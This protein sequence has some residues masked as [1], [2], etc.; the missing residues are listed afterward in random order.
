MTKLS[1]E[2]PDLPRARLSLSPEVLRLGPGSATIDYTHPSATAFALINGRVVAMTGRT[3]LWI[4]NALRAV[5]E[6][7]AASDMERAFL[8][9]QGAAALYEDFGV[10]FFPR[11]PDPNDLAWFIRSAPRELGQMRAITTSGRVWE[12]IA[13][14]G[15]RASVLSFWVEAQTVSEAALDFIAKALNLEGLCYVEFMDSEA[16]QILSR[17]AREDSEA[18]TGSDL[19]TL[20]EI[21][22]EEFGRCYPALDPTAPRTL[23]IPDLHNQIEH[24]DYWLSTQRYDRAVLLGDYFDSFDDTVEDARRTA[25]WLKERLHD[26]KLVFLLGNHD[27]PYRFA[28]NEALFC[29]GYS[30]AK[31]KEIRSILNKEDWREMKLACTSEGWLLS[32]AGFHPVWMKEPTVE[33]ILARCEMAERRAARGKLDPIFALGE[34]PGGVQ[35]FGGPLWMDWGA[36]RPIPGINQLVGHTSGETV[37]T[38]ILPGSMN[39]CIDIGNASV[40]AVL[41]KGE[42]QIFCINATQ[43]E[44]TH[45]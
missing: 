16:P 28:E 39:A 42:I 14:R 1:A 38:S 19:P 18:G 3:H 22:P 34:L 30:K 27:T 20:L 41:C 21:A 40:A 9:R 5:A 8:R 26:P 17:S 13:L 29:D 4:F 6:P 25:L 32:H 33:K 23:V 7:E 36:F 35:R 31:A 37:R 15:Q 10:R 12:N 44:N 11:L 24:A 43:K 2:N 45:V